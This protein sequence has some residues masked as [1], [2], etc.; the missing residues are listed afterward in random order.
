[1][2]LSDEPRFRPDLDALA[3]LSPAEIVVSYDRR[4]DTLMVHF[5]ARGRA[6]VSVPSPK[7]LARDFVFLRFDPAT[8]ELVGVQ[9]EDFLDLYLPANP[10]AAILI[11]RAELRGITEAEV[12]AELRRLRPDVGGGPS[13]EEVIEQL[14][15]LAA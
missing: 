9:I 7:P 6:A 13:S 14:V 10:K 11:E 15:L 3:R 1:M 2:A 4:S 5:G 8:G 12:V